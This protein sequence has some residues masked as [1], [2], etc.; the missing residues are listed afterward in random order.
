MSSHV[1]TVTDATALRV[2]CQCFRRSGEPPAPL[3]WPVAA[4]C[5]TKA[6]A[7]ASAMPRRHGVARATARDLVQLDVAPRPIQTV[8]GV[9][10]R[11]T[12]W[13]AAETD[14]ADLCLLRLA[15]G[16]AGRVR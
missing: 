9:R 8:R 14:R 10:R 13:D 6:R 15:A 16:R 2:P 12:W 5:T 7:S 11:G 1:I 4:H 3:P